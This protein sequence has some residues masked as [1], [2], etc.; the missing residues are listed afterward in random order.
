[1]PTIQCVT[2][3]ILVSRC[4]LGRDPSTLDA[5]RSLCSTPS[6]ANGTTQR[7]QS[8]QCAWMLLFVCFLRFSVCCSSD[9]VLSSWAAS[10]QVAEPRLIACLHAL[11]SRWMSLRPEELADSTIWYDPST[12]LSKFC[13]TALCNVLTQ[14]W[15]TK[16][17]QRFLQRNSATAHSYPSILLVLLHYSHHLQCSW[18]SVDKVRKLVR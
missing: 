13:F 15:E 3:L 8:I 9:A 11:I 10:C 12:L 5:L 7:P 1:M 16:E 17:T 14:C 4:M 2:V 6:D 18:P